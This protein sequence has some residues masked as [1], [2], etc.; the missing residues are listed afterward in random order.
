MLKTR[1]LDSMF[2]IILQLAVKLRQN[3]EGTHGRFYTQALVSV[4]TQV[5][6]WADLE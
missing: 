1:R 5:P 4:F 2:G 6:N 3:S